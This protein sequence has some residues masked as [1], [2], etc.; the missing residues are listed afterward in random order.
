MDTTEDYVVMQSNPDAKK[1]ISH[2]LLFVE[3][4]FKNKT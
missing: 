4:S 3:S 2:F 1:E